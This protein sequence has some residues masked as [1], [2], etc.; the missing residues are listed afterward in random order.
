[1]KLTNDFNGLAN[2]PSSIN[3]PTLDLLVKYMFILVNSLYF[4]VC[5][6]RQ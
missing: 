6:V 4:P 3:N 1:M 5:T 2:N